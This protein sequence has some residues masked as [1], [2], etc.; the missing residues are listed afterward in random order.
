MGVYT[1]YYQQ[2]NLALGG[3]FFGVEVQFFTKP[4]VYHPSIHS[5]MGKA[6][7]WHG[8]LCYPTT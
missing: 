1:T 5:F 2:S 6:K 4:L 7:L 3:N 8:Y